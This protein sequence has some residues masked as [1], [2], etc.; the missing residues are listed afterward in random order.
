MGKIDSPCARGQNEQ[1]N[2]QTNKRA[3]KER[4]RRKNGQKQENIE[5][6]NGHQATRGEI[7]GSTSKMDSLFTRLTAEER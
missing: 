4:K 3:N 2:K 1:T 5:G 7:D 6:K